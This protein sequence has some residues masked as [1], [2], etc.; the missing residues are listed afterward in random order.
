[1]KK[2]LAVWA[3][4]AI[5]A[6]AA[7][8]Q[9]YVTFNNSTVTKVSTNKVENGAST[10]FTSG[11]K[12]FYY[13]LYYS[14]STTSVNGQT[15]AI[16]GRTNVNYAFSDSAWTLAAYGTNLS[17]GIFSSANADA[18]GRTPV[19]GVAG[20]TSANFVVIGWSAG[21]G[22]TAAAVQTWFNSGAPA[23]EGWIG[24]SVVSG[25]IT[26]GASTATTL[27]G[28]NAAGLIRGFLLGRIPGGGSGNVA[29]SIS[30]Q[31]G[32]ITVTNGGS[33]SF[34]ITYAGTP[35]P[36]FQWFCN[37]TNI[38]GQTGDTLTLS[39]VSLASS[40]NSYFVTLT[41]SSGSVTSSNGVLTVT[42]GPANVA[43]FITVQPPN[44]TVTN[45]QSATFS[46]TSGGTP[47]PTFQ[48]FCNGTNIPGRTSA[49]L[50]LTNVTADSSGN[51]YFVTLTNVA[52]SVTS[53]NGVLT[54]LAG[55]SN[56]APFITV[57][58]ANKSTAYGSSASF[59][60]TYGGTPTPTFQWFCNGTN[61]PGKT[62]SVLTLN[63]VTFDSSGN[64]YFVTLT[65]SS[66]S[67]TSS[68]AVL[69]VTAPAAN[70]VFANT[71]TPATRIFTNSAAGGAATGLTTGAFLYRYALYVSTNA[72]DING[73]TAAILGNDSD[74]YAFNDANW[75][76][77]AYATNTTAGRL[78]SASAD[79]FG[80]TAV[81]YAAGRATARFVVIGWSAG[82]GTDISSVETW[83]NGG[84]PSS[85]GWIGQSAV[86]GAIPLGGALFSTNAPYLQGFTLGLVAGTVNGHAQYAVA[87]TSPLTMHATISGNNLNLSWPAA[88]GS[89]G[90]LSAASPDGPWNDTGLT[91]TSDGTTASATVQ[92]GEEQQYFR[93]MAQ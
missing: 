24:Q 29:P 54:V 5:A 36:T 31:P 64:T 18:S 27:F 50:T 93:L 23:T 21:I 44:R 61:I 39:N 84:A 32:N 74:D 87:I 35:A 90:V 55:P 78:T 41:N 85:D 51:Y 20:G 69:T 77:V 38:P 80:K 37:N 70:I 89:Y 56:A 14:T 9:G 12:T 45:G 13:A 63:N 79:A 58:P 67:V 88:A 26:P 30:V 71:T 47:T 34:S 10:G 16:S 83:Y 28:T 57:Q 53:S 62:S 46:V 3:I 52:G 43:P 15:A 19:P 40:G 81:T 60:V 59:S 91:V 4:T 75:S 86:S 73:Q 33:V 22:T 48:W 11:G 8:A 6:M 1:M 66:G 7:Q 2:N 68:N 65:N 17:G 92:V 49:T 82:I 72:A 76:L 25:A 42:S